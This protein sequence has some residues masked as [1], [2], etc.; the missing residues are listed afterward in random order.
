[1][2]TALRAK[3]PTDHL[4]YETGDFRGL[5]CVELDRATLAP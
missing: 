5:M 1:V 2:V 3:Y 4:G